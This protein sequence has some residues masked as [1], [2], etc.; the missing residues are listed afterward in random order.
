M[1]PGSNDGSSRSHGAT[2]RLLD[3]AVDTFA[4]NGFEAATVAQIARMAGFTTGA[5]YARWYGK[6]DLIVAAVGYIASNRLHLPA[7]DEE[8]SAADALAEACEGLFPATDAT[9]R[10]VMLEACVT[11]RRDDSFRAAVAD[12]MEAEAAKL[13]D[14]VTRAKDE[15]SIDPDLSTNAIVALY[16]AVS[17]GMHLVASSQPEGRRVRG[18]E[19]DALMAR[20]LEATSPPPAPN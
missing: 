10:D 19:W 15:G 9:A 7:V 17:L 1:D 16:Q 18:E 8:A 14:I 5:I 11:A 13:A 6:R 20:L 3:A 4:E 12:S 2:E